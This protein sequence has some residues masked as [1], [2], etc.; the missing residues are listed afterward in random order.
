MGGLVEEALA[1][2][3]LHEIRTDPQRDAAVRIAL[4]ATAALLGVPGV[5]GAPLRGMRSL[6]V[7]LPSRLRNF[8]P[9]AVTEAQYRRVVHLLDALELQENST[10]DLP[11]A[12]SELAVWCRA[13]VSY[14]EKRSF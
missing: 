7:A 11:A 5:D 14:V 2:R 1:R 13:A 10:A 3:Q 12:A 4:Q 8:R 9:D 6:L